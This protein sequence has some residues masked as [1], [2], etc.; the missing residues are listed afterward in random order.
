MERCETASEDIEIDRYKVAVGYSSTA[1]F[2]L[3][4]IPSVVKS[5]HGL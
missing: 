4:P 1:I 5:S 3:V 2:T